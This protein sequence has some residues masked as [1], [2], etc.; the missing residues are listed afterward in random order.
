MDGTVVAYENWLSPR[1]VTHEVST[2]VCKNVALIAHAN[3][4]KQCTLQCNDL[5]AAICEQPREAII[6]DSTSSV[7]PPPATPSTDSS[8]I[9]DVVVNDQ[10]LNVEDVE[11]N[12]IDI[13]ER[14]Q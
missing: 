7:S 5:Q 2:A 8:S 10:I 12:E 14:E 6:E 1:C 3:L 4:I 13:D 9:P 11:L